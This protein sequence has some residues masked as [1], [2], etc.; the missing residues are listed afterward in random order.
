MNILLLYKNSTYAGY[1]L[2]D[3]KRLAQLEGLLEYP[4]RSSVFGARMRIIFGACLMW[5][6]F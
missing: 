1:F 5:K 2:S 4:K 6:L 3:R